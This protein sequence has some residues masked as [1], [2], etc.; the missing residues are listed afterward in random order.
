LQIPG[1]AQHFITS[2]RPAPQDESFPLFTYPEC[3]R[4]RGGNQHC[5]HHASYKSRLHDSSLAFLQ[6]FDAISFMPDELFS[7][8]PVPVDAETLMQILNLEPEWCQDNTP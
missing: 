4:A 7:D 3:R 5:Y 1:L 6:R 8:N 2:L